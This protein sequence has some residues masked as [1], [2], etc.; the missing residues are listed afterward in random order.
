MESRDLEELEKVL[1]Y[2]FN[3]KNHLYTALTHKSYVNEKM[4][5][6]RVSYERYEFLGDAI[7]EYLT[8]RF[9]FE[10]YPDKP[11]G[12]LAKVGEVSEPSTG[13]TME[14]YTDLPGMQMYSGNFIVKEDGKNGAEYTKRT[15]ICFETQYFPNSINL[16]QFKSC[17]LKAGEK[18]N[19]TTIYKF[20]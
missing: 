13:R 16:P 8:S 17:V 20:I 2:K 3:D 11:E 14:I 6:H 15:G 1:G 12:E 5:G 18:F 10:E 9:L 4:C 7:L 19:S